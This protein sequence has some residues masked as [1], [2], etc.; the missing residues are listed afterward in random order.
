MIARSRGQRPE[1]HAR[2]LYSIAPNT[3]A[4]P[5]T[6]TPCGREQRHVNG[7]MLGRLQEQEKWPTGAP[8]WLPLKFCI[9]MKRLF[10]K[11]TPFKSNP[12]APSN[13]KSIAAACYRR[14]EKEK[15]RKYERR[16]LDVK[17]GS[18][19]PLVFSMS[20]GW[21]PSS[22]MTEEAITGCHK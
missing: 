22:W 16:V 13:N 5:V 20:G 21:G 2:A 3:M 11:K 8:I 9:F 6:K 4:K 1:I 10:Y 19:T 7:Y 17:H 14:H 18:F 15:W 12:Y